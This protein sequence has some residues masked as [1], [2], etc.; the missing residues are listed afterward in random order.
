MELRQRPWHSPLPLLKT[1]L[2]PGGGFR[3]LF[4]VLSTNVQSLG[5]TPSLCEVGG[6]GFSQLMFF[7]HHAFARHSPDPGDAV[8]EGTVLVPKALSA[9]SEI[10]NR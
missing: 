7:E 2:C 10:V 6:R 8:L 3:F 9:T 1:W 4:L 5:T